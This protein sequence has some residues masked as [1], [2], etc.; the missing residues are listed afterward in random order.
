M[1]KWLIF[2]EF[3]FQ[4]VD[5]IFLSGINSQQECPETQHREMQIPVPGK[6]IP[7]LPVKGEE[8]IGTN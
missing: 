7:T 2:S 4:S 1:L 3:G 5:G 8:T 6:Y